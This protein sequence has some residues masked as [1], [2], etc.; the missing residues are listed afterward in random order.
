MSSFLIAGLE[1][2]GLWN[3]INLDLKF[4]Q[5]VNVIIGP[6][7]SGKTTILNFLRYV[8]TA[9]L[10][11]LYEIEFE[12][13]TIRLRG[14]TNNSRRTIKIRR[15]DQGLTVAT[16]HNF[17]IP[18]ESLLTARRG[19]RRSVQWGRSPSNEA[20]DPIQELM[21]LVP[22]VWLPVS[23]RLPIPER[24]DEDDVHEFWKTSME[25]RNF[26]LESVDQR[27]TELIN[28]LQR[29]RLSLETQLSERYKDFERRVL[30]LMLFNPDHDKWP[31]R[32]PT[33][34]LDE[35]QKELLVRAFAAAGLLNEGMR[36]RIDEHF[37]VAYDVASKIQQTKGEL[38]PQDIFVLP[39]VPRT[40]EMIAAA[41]QLEEARESLFSPLRKFE[42]IASSFLNNKTV[43]VVDNGQLQVAFESPPAQTIAPERLSSGEKQILILLTQALLRENVP[44]VY[45]VD[46][47]ELSLHVS[48]QEKLLQSLRELGGQIQIIVA[49]HSPD[50]V[51]PYRDKVIDLGARR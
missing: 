49:T 3:R 42:K 25:I 39:L 2:K 30:E 34:E 19:V 43:H 17:K 9:D 45:V 41:R 18:A 15:D 24:A 33:G 47:P 38:D 50:I 4:Y 23:R 13:A 48:W 12:A 32:I 36:K 10:T 46:E 22:A 8:L 26:R 29:Y 14:F 7:A 31:F 35:E 51:G 5:D 1:I 6:N 20:E 11:R 44:V 16:P 28:D 27:L 37:S 40:R 21:A